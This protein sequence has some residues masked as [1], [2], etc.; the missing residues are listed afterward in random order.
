PRAGR[1]RRRARGRSREKE[2]TA[3]PP[4]RGG[5][6]P[7]APR[8]TPGGRGWRNAAVSSAQPPLDGEAVL[9]HLAV[10]G[11]AREAEGF[12]GLGDD[13]VGLPKGA[14]DA[15]ALGEEQVVPLGLAGGRGGAGRGAP[16]E[17]EVLHAQD[18][19]RR[20]EHGPPQGVLQ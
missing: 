8:E 19:S 9:L 17:P 12:R 1:P 2:P 14:L 7:A 11:L 3:L 15:D 16:P 10:E 5:S 18:V 13:A 6:P 4:W 20:H